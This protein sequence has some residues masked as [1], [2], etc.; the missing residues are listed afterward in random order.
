VKIDCNLTLRTSGLIVSTHNKVTDDFKQL[1]EQVLI[2]GTTYV[3]QYTYAQFNLPTG[4]AILLYYQG[5]VVH[6]ITPS[7]DSYEDST[8]SSDVVI[9][10]MDS[11]PDQYTIDSLQLWATYQNILLYPIASAQ[12]PSPVTK[13]GFI[14]VQ[15][16]IIVT[17]NASTVPQ[18]VPPVQIP[19]GYALPFTNFSTSTFIATLLLVPLQ[20]LQQYPESNFMVYYNALNG[21]VQPLNGV[22]AVA[23]VSTTPPTQTQ[24]VVINPLSAPQLQ[25]VA[26]LTPT[27]GCALTQLNVSQYYV[28]AY[29]GFGNV[30][31]PLVTV[32][33]TGNGTLSKLCVEVL[34][35]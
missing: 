12:L 15:W 25:V 6:M 11:S 33:L 9:Q 4:Y 28:I 18:N 34:L 23:I 21:V 13:I 19:G 2:N 10:G 1:L 5:V 27:Q 7:V 30:R 26:T 20:V 3:S 32:L 8:L 35:S 22:V 29:Y 24:P 17:S 14:S 16:E 31:V